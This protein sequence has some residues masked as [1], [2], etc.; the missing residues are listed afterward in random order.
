M[1]EP[2][3]S[4][5]CDKMQVAVYDSNA[6]LGMAAAEDLAEILRQ[7]VAEQGETSIIVAT[8]NSQLLFMEACV[9]CRISPGI[10][11]GLPHG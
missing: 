7:A 2:L 9:P 4:F 11:S 3:K 6:S 10:R 5:V 1:V 8:G